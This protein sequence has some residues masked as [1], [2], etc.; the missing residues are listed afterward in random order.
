MNVSAKHLMTGSLTSSHSL[1]TLLFM[2]HLRYQTHQVS[3]D[4]KKLCIIWKIRTQIGQL[5]V[6]TLEIEQ[7]P[8]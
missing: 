4:F 1:W 6:E 2:L 3:K 8:N 7:I 5:F